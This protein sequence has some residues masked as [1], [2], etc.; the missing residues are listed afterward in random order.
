MK[1]LSS[2]LNEIAE[3]AGVQLNDQKLID[4]LA[5]QP[6]STI[7]VPDEISNAISGQLISLDAAKDN[8]PQIKTHY[9]GEIMNNID[10][11]LKSVY[12]AHPDIF[13]DTTIAELGNEKS[14]TKRIGL[15]ANKIKEKNNGDGR[16]G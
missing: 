10:R 6:L 12:E 5:H 1:S 15:V 4:L 11:Q 7:M 13:D 9:F 14:S 16:C 3:K 8:H 2:I